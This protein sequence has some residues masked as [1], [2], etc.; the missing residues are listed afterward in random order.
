MISYHLRRIWSQ[1]CLAP[2]QGRGRKV[3]SSSLWPDVR[4]RQR[5]EAAE[6]ID[7]CRHS[8][9]SVKPS[10]LQLELRIMT[11]ETRSNKYRQEIEWRTKMFQLRLTS[12]WLVFLRVR[13]CSSH[14]LTLRLLHLSFYTNTLDG[15]DIRSPPLDRSTK[16]PCSWRQQERSSPPTLLIFL[17]VRNR[18]MATG[19]GA[20]RGPRTANTTF[21]RE[22]VVNY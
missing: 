19:F 12:F 5:S 16:H 9:I 22:G 14:P 21:E 3:T 13:P 17:V 4:K 15:T 20:S 1:S 11:A 10:L 8:S 7:R 2:L 6:D 18:G